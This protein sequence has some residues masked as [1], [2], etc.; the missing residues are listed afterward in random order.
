M[1]LDRH[2]LGFKPGEERAGAPFVR[3]RDL[4]AANFP[5]RRVRPDIT[6]QGAAEQLMSETHAQHRLLPG[7]Q[8]RD[9][10]QQGPHVRIVV[11][12]QEGLAVA[13][14]AVGSLLA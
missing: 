4:A 8:S 13:I 9:E 3:E 12:M 14:F 11:V 2:K 7:D 10:I 1:T 6:P 5:S